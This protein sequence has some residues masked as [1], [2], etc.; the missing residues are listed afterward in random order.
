[1]ALIVDIPA[2]RMLSTEGTR[3]AKAIL[4]SALAHFVVIV[5]WK[6]GIQDWQLGGNRTL[7]VSFR[8]AAT[9]KEQQQEAQPSA[10]ANAQ[11]G[12]PILTQKQSSV[13]LAA[14][15][16]AVSPPTPKTMETRTQAKPQVTQESKVV[17]PGPE[18]QSIS[19]RG[20][21]NALLTIGDDGD[22][23]QIIWKDLP[24]LTNAQLQRLESFLRAKKYGPG[25]AGRTISE[26][27]DLRPFLTE[28]ANGQGA[29]VRQDNNS[30]GNGN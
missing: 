21:F 4:F 25:M 3:L 28:D 9:V 6:Q 10:P 15:Q 23:G 11:N 24:A 30:R 17:A 5:A 26:T 8:S 27:V 1:M 14:P 19:N 29:V 16:A 7:T 2:Q 12:T 22:V 13:A 20:L 18:A